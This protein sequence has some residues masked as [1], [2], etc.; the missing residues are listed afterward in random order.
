M[1]GPCRLP[2]KA[3]PHEPW[4]KD[5]KEAFRSFWAMGTRERLAMEVLNWTGAR[6][7]DAVRF[8]DGMIDREGWLNLSQKKRVVI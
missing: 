5:D 7:S 6:M 2:A 3:K 1:R 8:S 4:T